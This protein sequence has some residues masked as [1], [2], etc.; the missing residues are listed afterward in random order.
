MYLLSQGSIGRFQRQWR[1]F[2]L[3][4]MWFLPSSLNV[5]VKKF[6]EARVNGGSN[7]DSLKGVLV[8]FLIKVGRTWLGH[9]G[10]Y[11][12]WQISSFLAY[13]ELFVIASIVKPTMCINRGNFWVKHF[14]MLFR[15]SVLTLKSQIS[16]LRLVGLYQVSVPY[17]V[18]FTLVAE[19][20]FVLYVRWVNAC[21]YL[22]WF[23]TE[24]DARENLAWKGVI[25]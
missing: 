15:T 19:K 24:V 17:Q 13:G 23:R 8:M 18:S 9:M 10:F 5:K 22:R 20:V 12:A 11:V 3:N 4:V 2:R 6:N 7:Y 14:R 1:Q 25:G 16:T 21:W